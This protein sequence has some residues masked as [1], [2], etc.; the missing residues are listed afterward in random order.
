MGGDA[1]WKLYENMSICNTC[2][3]QLAQQIQICY[4]HSNEEMYFQGFQCQVSFLKSSAH[5]TDPY[6]C[7]KTLLP[8]FTTLA[9]NMMENR[10]YSPALIMTI[11]ELKNQ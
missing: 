6:L 8:S 7:I 4:S 2:I 1:Y 9:L 10:Y 3:Y 11:R 5:M